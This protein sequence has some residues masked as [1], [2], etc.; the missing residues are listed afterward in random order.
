MK[1]FVIFIA[2]IVI[3]VAIT[4]CAPAIKFV[5]CC[6]YHQGICGC[7]EDGTILCCDGDPSPTCECRQK[8]DR[9]E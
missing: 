4:C 3:A 2:A 5:G 8:E 9:D 7:L 1:P 6:S